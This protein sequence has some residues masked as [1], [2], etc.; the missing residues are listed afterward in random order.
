MI[1]KAISNVFKL[2]I[3]V[4]LAVVILKE[5]HKIQSYEAQTL[6]VDTSVNM[7]CVETSFPKSC[8]ERGQWLQIGTQKLIYVYSAYFIRSRKR[9]YVIGIKPMGRVD[10][11]CHIWSR[12]GNG[13]H[14]S[15]RETKAEV[16]V[17]DILPNRSE[18]INFT[19]YC[20]L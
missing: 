17:P 18:H 2:T 6:Y 8:N 10:L 5:Y 3:F 11:I 19:T 15:L 4:L 12:S 9:V 14:L 13:K 1:F 16:R 20:C 7:S